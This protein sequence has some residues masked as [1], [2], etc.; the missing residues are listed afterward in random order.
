LQGVGRVKFFGR[1]LVRVG[2]VVSCGLLVC[3]SLSFKVVEPSFAQGKKGKSAEPARRTTPTPTPTPIPPVAKQQ[4]PPVD[5][6]LNVPVIPPPISREANS[7]AQPPV[8]PGTQPEKKPGKQPGKEPEN[9]GDTFRI[10]SNLVAV[11]VSVTDANGEPMRQLRAEDFQLEEEGHAQQ[12][13]SLGEPGKT[14]LELA[15]LFDLSG[16]VRE[17]FEFEKMAATRF[18][19]EVLKPADSVTV[20]SIG[21]DPKLVAERTSSLE[22]VAASLNALQP[23]KEGTAFFDT[24]AKAAKYLGE[25]AAPGSRRVVLVISDGEDNHSESHRLADTQR[26]LQR[27]D[28]LFYAI[29]PSGPSIRLNRISMRGHNGMA[30]LAAETGGVAFLPDQDAELEKVFRQIAAELQAQYLL[31]YYSSNETNDGKF[32]R[33]KIQ[34]PKR[35]DLRIRAR[36]GYYAPKD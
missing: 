30:T 11:P 18:L 31:G 26:E 36:Q 15:L 23:T 10:N 12:L 35:P 5:Y 20:F 16:S 33:I 32:R 28:T 27:T 19:K 4:V 22:R 21:F 9:S 29:N 8:K 34:L 24:V 17:R 1:I 13:Q 25:N 2:L 3:A 6:K 7:A 14:P